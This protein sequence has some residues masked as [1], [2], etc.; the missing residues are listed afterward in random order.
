V[1]AHEEIVFVH[2][3]RPIGYEIFVATSAL[4]GQG[5]APDRGADAAKRAAGRR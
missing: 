2:Q 3:E 4:R 5:A 1:G